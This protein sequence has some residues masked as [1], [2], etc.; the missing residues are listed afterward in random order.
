[1]DVPTIMGES[2]ALQVADI[3]RLIPRCGENIREKPVDPYH[4]TVHH[5]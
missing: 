2:A 3:Y 5:K 1:M 4:S